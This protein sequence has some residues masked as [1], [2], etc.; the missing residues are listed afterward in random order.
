MAKTIIEAIIEHS[1]ANPN[2]IC[3]ADGKCSI[4]YYE[5]VSSIKKIGSY[6]YSKKIK[7]GDKVILQSSSTC[8][9][10]QILLALQFIK[11]VVVPIDATASDD[12]LKSIIKAVSPSL[13]ILNSNKNTGCDF[14]FCTVNDVCCSAMQCQPIDAFCFPCKYDI[15]EIL[16]TTGTTGTHKGIM[17]TFDNN[18]A[19]SEN[20][21]HS[22]DMKDDNVELIF[23]PLNHS[24]GLRRLYAN[25]YKGTTVVLHSNIAFVSDV[26]YKIEKYNVNS[27]DFV[28]S[29]LSILL[30][31]GLEKFA[32]YANR[33]RYI[34][35]GGASVKKNEI[36][37]L[38]KYFPDTKL[39]NMY[40]STE[41][42]ISIAHEYNNKGE[43]KVNC[44]GKPTFNSFI[45]IVDE[46]YQPIQS[47][48]D[49]PGFIA[50]KSRANM[51]GYYSQDGDSISYDEYVNGTIYSNDLAYIDEDG[52]IILLGRKGVV[53][54]TGGYK[55]VPQE[56]EQIAL[57]YEKIN[58][59]ACIGIDDPTLGQAPVLFITLKNSV[60]IDMTELHSF[61]KSR[62]ESYK[63]PKYIKAIDS[64]PRS[65]KGSVLYASLKEKEIDFL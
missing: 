57:E 9:Y 64:I 26:F 15:C 46:N 1:K 53:I 10:M 18:V 45:Q 62:L 42:G 17:M 8:Q 20:V 29:A 47:S 30:K 34:Q 59:C 25:L 33:I 41:S 43:D 40:G 54:N 13:I 38:K 6:L 2:R 24:H 7:S 39:I 14:C 19:L 55:I 28:P 16:F 50:T 52:D 49:N 27:F 31:L 32:T 61:L 12:S 37:L 48:K 23:A 5:L 35:F 11:A 22:T 63:I 65:P 4:S 3:L 58:D 21:I 60:N 51:K 44:I 36:D 56:I